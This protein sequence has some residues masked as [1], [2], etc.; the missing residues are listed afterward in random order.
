MNNWLESFGFEQ[1][2]D[3]TFI[4]CL[5]K[6]FDWIGYQYNEKGIIGVAPRAFENHIAKLNRLYEQDRCQGLGF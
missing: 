5:K 6:G 3:K 2:P 1:H 4:G